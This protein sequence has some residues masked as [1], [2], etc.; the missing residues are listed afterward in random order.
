MRI[1]KA[2]SIEIESTLRETTAALA[3]AAMKA[4]MRDGNVRMETDPIV[5][6]NMGNDALLLIEKMFDLDI[7]VN[8]VHE[9]VSR[10]LRNAL[11]G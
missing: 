5:M 11:L 1:K 4:G 2:S 10:W 9:G 6:Q 7:G 8:C 3:D